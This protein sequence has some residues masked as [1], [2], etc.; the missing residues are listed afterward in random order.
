MVSAF[1]RRRRLTPLAQ[2]PRPLPQKNPVHFGL[3][4]RRPP[5]ERPENCGFRDPNN[6]IEIRGAADLAKYIVRFGSMRTLGVMGVRGR[7]E[8]RRGQ[9]VV[10]RSNR[11]LEVGYVLCEAS[12]DAM[13]HL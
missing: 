3:R 11:G 8:Y 2:N 13:S 9:D 7:D 6:T 10:V 12:D 4:S 1:L 5:A